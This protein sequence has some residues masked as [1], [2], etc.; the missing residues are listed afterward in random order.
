MGNDYAL[1]TSMKMHSES[2][3]FTSSQ[4]KSNVPISTLPSRDTVSTRGG[5][6]RRQMSQFNVLQDA[7]E[8]AL[9]E[10]GGASSSIAYNRKDHRYLINDHGSPLLR[11]GDYQTKT[12]KHL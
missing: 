12:M 2:L 1:D 7:S 6:P 4:Y 8:P 10:G 5:E 11:S 3:P 9:V